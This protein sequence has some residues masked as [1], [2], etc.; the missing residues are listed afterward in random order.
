M[1]CRECNNLLPLFVDE[2]LTQT[3]HGLV[4]NHLADCCHCREEFDLLSRAV[5]LV[6]HLPQVDA[7]AD[8]HRRLLARLD[9]ETPSR[10]SWNFWRTLTL[11]T[12]AAAAMVLLTLII[13]N[14]IQKMEPMFFPKPASATSAPAIS[15]PNSPMSKPDLKTANTKPEVAKRSYNNE[16]DQIYKNRTESQATVAES[17]KQSE[18]S[19]EESLDFAAENRSADRDDI[20]ATQSALYH[21][22][23]TSPAAPVYPVALEQSAV[24][25]SR[26]VSPLYREKAE[27]TGEY[28]QVTSRSTKIL[29]SPQA[30]S[31]LWSEA[32]ITA[33]PVPAVDWDRQ[34][35]GMIFLGNRPGRGY[36]VQLRAVQ[37]SPD[38]IL[39][40]YHVA[41]P[42]NK[43]GNEKSSQPFLAFLLPATPLPVLF[44]EE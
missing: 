3:E 16:K 37:E 14:P 25:K 36:E 5:H 43:N 15:S 19:V 1:D 31:A 2:V 29:R 40:R 9:Q 12:V 38:K 4:K 33:L 41:A 32:R 34:M 6:C 7:P 24:P 42:E 8:F 22:V 39:V 18:K 27:W 30:L 10:V 28:C 35:L 26:M 11:S 13:Y 44:Q 23:D 21:P 20:K 17:E